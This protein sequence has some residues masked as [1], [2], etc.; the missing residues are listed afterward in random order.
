MIFILYLKWVPKYFW[1]SN[2]SFKII[3]F[4]CETFPKKVIQKNFLLSTFIQ[5]G[6]QRFLKSLPNWNRGPSRHRGIP[7]L[8]THEK[9]NR[10]FLLL[11]CIV[12]P[13]PWNKVCSYPSS[14]AATKSSQYYF[15]KHPEHPAINWIYFVVTNTAALTFL[16][17]FILEQ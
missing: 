2:G 14:L 4:S 6:L 8:L 17:F 9:I 1:C 5:N 7:F 16:S 11:L 13:L 10:S 15:F 12:F 3:H